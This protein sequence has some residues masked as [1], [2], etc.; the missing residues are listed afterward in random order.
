MADDDRNIHHHVHDAA[1]PNADDADVDDVDNRSVP[2]D[3]DHHHYDH[4]HGRG[5]GGR[6]VLLAGGRATA[7]P[8]FSLRILGGACVTDVKPT[9][10]VKGEVEFGD[11]FVLRVPSLPRT[12]LD[13]LR[14]GYD[15][16][17]FLPS[18]L[19]H[20]EQIEEGVFLAS[21]SLYRAA[22]EDGQLTPAAKVS[23]SR[24]IFR[25]A[26]RCTPYGAFSAV[27]L[28]LIGNATNLRLVRPSESKRVIRLDQ[29][30]VGAAQAKIFRDAPPLEVLRKCAVLINGSAWRAPDGWRY[31]EARRR[32]DWTHY[33]L[34]RI[35]NSDA[36]DEVAEM[37]NQ[38]IQFEALVE[39]LVVRHSAARS[40][41][42][43]FLTRLVSEQFILAGPQVSVTG[44]D[45][46]ADFAHRLAE[47]KIAA[48]ASI[49]VTSAQSKI[50]AVKNVD[51]AV[52]IMTYKS[53]HACFDDT[54]IEADRARLVQ[55]DLHLSGEPVTLES[56]IVSKIAETLAH[57]RPILVRR[58]N[59][60]TDFSQQFERR[61]GSQRVPLL[62][63]LDSDFGVGYGSQT[64]V[65]TPLV[66]GV[67]PPAPASQ[68][69][70][71][72]EMDVFLLNRAQNAAR[73]KR[74]SIELTK[75]D[76]AKFSSK[77]SF[78]STAA[79]LGSLFIQDNG[80]F[81]FDLSGIFGPP[82]GTLLGRFGSGNPRLAALLA[83]F[84]STADSSDQPIV[85]EIVHMPE[86]RVGN[87]VIRPVL[88]Q[89]EIAYLGSAGVPVDRVLSP[90]DLEL[91]CE[92]GS[93]FLWHKPSGR[94]VIPRMSNAHNFDN[95]LNLP[96][97]RF[98]GALGRQGEP[99]VGWSWGAIGSTLS[100][101]PEV[102]FQG[103]RLSR[104]R[105]T[106]YPVEVKKIVKEGITAVRVVQG[107]RGIPDRIRVVEG[108]NYLEL[109]LSHNL[110]QQLF[111]DAA[112]RRPSL[113]IE[114]APAIDKS[115]VHDVSGAPYAN[116]IAIPLRTRSKG[117]DV[118]R[119]AIR[120]SGENAANWAPGSEWLYARIYC[121]SSTADD[122]I[123][124][125][126]PRFEHHARSVGCETPFFI[127]YAEG[128]SHLRI[129][130]KGRP[131]VLW[132][133]IR[134]YLE[135]DLHNL[136]K[137][138]AVSALEYCTYQPEYDR[139][140]GRAGTAYCETIFALDS[141]A[142][143]IALAGFG[144]RPDREELRWQFALQS[145]TKLAEF[146]TGNLEECVSVIEAMRDGYL[147]EFGLKV[148]DL[149][150]LVREHRPVAWRLLSGTEDF[151][152]S[153]ALNGRSVGIRTCLD[154][155]RENSIR[156]DRTIIHSLLHM[157]ANRIFPDMARFHE[158][159]LLQIGAKVLRSIAAKD[160]N[161]IPKQRELT[162][163]HTN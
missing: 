81:G 159:V 100:W 36:I 120:A 158:L 152:W 115:V 64:K 12:V 73:E 106:L 63:A 14:H 31:V 33:E 149:D 123:S 76:V 103:I 58:A 93:V 88:S 56:G 137:T 16:D 116:E 92:A 108:D 155:A 25:M 6:L 55:V 107:Q 89:Y 95:A 48:P 124:N 2:H 112:R 19:E 129:R 113:Q 78:P 5:R 15:E 86:G 53:I 40:D 21:S 30:V 82:A 110:D 85:A 52:P 117:H 135:A 70:S 145:M 44:D 130:V 8:S 34:A 62:E 138:R 72:T 154:A 119:K 59:N 79:A 24:Y 153:G 65:R 29:A 1:R 57:L 23:L 83:D 27:G 125:H 111:L 156:L 75:T 41:V 32:S 47:L 69:V 121:G 132:T 46:V 17:S 144:R 11:F 67:I 54:S 143:A 22:F 10:G 122:W 163:A 39:R 49:A 80:D 9:P 102:T 60:L 98:L 147:L 91:A 140:G 127:R 142:T 118:P 136:L 105:W 84:Q 148:H 160:G 162:L 157:C 4:H 42:E 87:V 74:S 20:Q 71:F 97:Y 109:D 7:L 150:P 90:G 139:Y 104:E 66:K 77:H 18:I 128:G 51:R 134:S 3:H 35:A 141:L 61:Y 28:G 151:E 50:D 37:V 99:I 146:C 26:T 68:N 161:P 45:P 38:E 131:E 101:T 43:A 133:D 96:V 13:Q 94:R 126:Y 114:R